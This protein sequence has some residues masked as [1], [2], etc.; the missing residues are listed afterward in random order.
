MLL[1]YES[2]YRDPGRNS[3]CPEY[4]TGHQGLEHSTQ[5]QL[6]FQVIDRQIAVTAVHISATIHSDYY[7]KSH[8]PGNPEGLGGYRYRPAV[9]AWLLTDGRRNPV[10]WTQDTTITGLQPLRTRPFGQSLRQGC[11]TPD[12]MITGLQ[13]LRTR[14]FGESLRQEWTLFSSEIFLTLARE[15]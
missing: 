14:P 6:R 9:R 8:T 13:P 1:S 10:Q 12:T 7:I 4:E 11:R 5:L 2:G 3:Q 15:L